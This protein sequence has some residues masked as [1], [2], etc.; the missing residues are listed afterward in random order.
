MPR[1]RL[2]LAVDLG[3]TKV[4]A[5]AAKVGP[6]GPALAAHGHAP[7]SALRRGVVVD[8]AAA[9]AAV[10][11]A[12]GPV[13]AALRE[14]P[15][16]AWVG[17]TGS[18]LACCNLDGAAPVPTPEQGIS[19]AEIDTALQVAGSSM[20]LPADREV[21]HAI[22]R[23]FT[24]DGQE[25]VRNPLSMAAR[26]LGV[27]THVITGLTTLLD[28]VE[29]AVGQAG[30]TVEELVFEPIASAHAVLSPAERDLG[31]LVVDM[32][33]GTTDF[34]LFADGAV[35]H[36]GAVPL[37][38]GQVTR[39]L[40]MALR[41]E[42][43]Q[44]EQLKLEHGHCL[45]EQVA[46]EE[47][48]EVTPL[49]GTTQGVQRRYVAGIIE[50]RLEE[51]LR[52]LKTEVLKSAQAA[53]L[54]GGM[55]LTGGGCRLPGLLELAERITGWP[56]RYGEARGITAEPHLLADPAW[57]T[58][59]GLLIYAAEQERQPIVEPKRRPWEWLLRLLG[60]GR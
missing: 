22:P 52:L 51:T 4:L 36:S 57:A 41:L 26:T 50:A 10:S 47:L 58:G 49:G 21:V 43:A 15:P 20:P 44:A 40:A 7:C 32:G 54:P 38:G 25:G 45:Y 60:M 42:P 19:Q 37:G 35:C 5:L 56:A 30:L 28:N 17:V 27:S 31:T 33:G 2:L 13:L 55:V 11:E 14:P 34:A 23:S 39:D 24:I 8:L 12:V 59:L 29:K 46:E 48:V 3:T 1:P 6:G 18:H 16:G 53:H 9:A